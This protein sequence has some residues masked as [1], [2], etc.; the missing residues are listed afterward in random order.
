MKITN[1]HTHTLYCG[2]GKGHPIDY[3]E[4][5]KEHNF[6]V[7]GFSE[8]APN[9][10]KALGG[11]PFEKIELYY[12]EVNALKNKYPDL[13]V[14]CGLEVDYFETFHPYYKKLKEKYDYLS[15]SC[16]YIRCNTPNPGQ[17]SSFH[18]K[19]I[20]DCNVYKDILI[21]GMHSN[22][23]SFINHPDLFIRE[24]L[25]GY[26]KLTKEIVNEAIKCNLPLEFNL[27]QFRARNELYQ[28]NNLRYKFWQYVGKTNA[29]VIINFD[30]HY[31]EFLETDL[32]QQAIS[33][34]KKLNLKLIDR[35]NIK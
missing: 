22:L 10:I 4:I 8:H 18:L 15:L 13:E 27:N 29:K 14:L 19:N 17:Y 5:A 30:A 20:E 35:I 21:K 7:L 33:L 16:H 6:K 25:D 1:Y 2:H 12:N 9:I 3:Y 34:S 32:Y 28:E 31:P 11:V 23:F 24:P 26:E